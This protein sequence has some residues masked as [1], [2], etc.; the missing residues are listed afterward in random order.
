MVKGSVE[1]KKFRFILCTLFAAVIV[2]GISSV[3]AF[4]ELYVRSPAIDE[5]LNKYAEESW[6]ESKLRMQLDMEDQN[7]AQA[8][9][10]E[11]GFLVT[12]L[13][14][15]PDM[16][17]YPITCDG[18]VLA[19]VIQGEYGYSFLNFDFG[20]N[21]LVTSAKSPAD[22]YEVDG[23]YFAVI[24]EKYF[25]IED[26]KS[27]MNKSSA[28]EINA[29]AQKVKEYRKENPSNGKYINAYC[30]EKSGW[31]TVGGKKYFIKKNGVLANGWQTIGGSKYYFDKNSAAVT[32]DTTIKNKRYRFDSDGK[33]LG[34][35]TGFWKSGGKQYYYKKGVKQTG[36]FTVDGKTYH[37]DKNGAILKK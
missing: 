31:R 30:F 32:K 4:A 16:Y 1:M 24:D 7:K 36:D 5:E 28:K 23:I 11:R 3:S 21:N 14:K 10:F 6:Q 33:Y 13:G 20:F 19:M 2:A 12:G 29:A 17:I 27:A 22:I 8:L 25:P 37:T 26:Y 18:E 9:K 35:Y 15:S 34:T